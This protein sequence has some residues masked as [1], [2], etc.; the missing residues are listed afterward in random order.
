MM[1]VEVEGTIWVEVSALIG[2]MGVE[3]E[4]TIGG[5][6][7]DLIGVEV[8]GLAGVEGFG[9]VL[10]DE[11]LVVAAV[12]LVLLVGWGR[13]LDAVAGG[14][15]FGG[16]EAAVLAFLC[17]VPVALLPFLLLVFLS[18][19]RPW[20]YCFF[21]GSPLAPGQSSGFCPFRHFLKRKVQ[22]RKGYDWPHNDNNNKRRILIHLCVYKST[23][24]GN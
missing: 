6:V 10:E 16:P 24:K 1:G 12:L 19:G 18:P 14:F 8:V 7:V 23:C 17:T 9:W 21:T 11:V 2:V 20:G 13:D 4:R 15:L 22:K 5:E 3:I